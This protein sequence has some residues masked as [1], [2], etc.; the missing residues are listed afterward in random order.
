MGRRRTLGTRLLDEVVISKVKAATIPPEI[1]QQIDNNY[2]INKYYAF[3]ERI[4]A[5]AGDMS[6]S[7]AKF[8]VPRNNI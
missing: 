4:K 8:P 2:K 1:P 6:T 3:L 5:L 7:Q